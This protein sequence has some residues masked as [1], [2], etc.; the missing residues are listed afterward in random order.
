VGLLPL[1]SAST[2]ASSPRNDFARNHRAH[3]T[4]W[5]I[6][7]QV[8]TNRTLVPRVVGLERDA[9]WLP[10][11]MKCNTDGP[12]VHPSPNVDREEL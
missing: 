11:D 8:L 5:L 6:C 1:D 12:A 9:D 2:A 4:H 7:A 10:L 3:P